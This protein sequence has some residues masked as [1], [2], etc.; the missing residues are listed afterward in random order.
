MSD[1]LRDTLVWTDG[2]NAVAVM[3]AFDI[4]QLIVGMSDNRQYD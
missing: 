3:W 2:K 4:D 1:L